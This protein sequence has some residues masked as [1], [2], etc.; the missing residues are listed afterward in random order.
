MGLLKKILELATPQ[1]TYQ[2]PT[3]DPYEERYFSAMPEIEAMWSVLYNLK[4]VTGEKADMFEQKCLQNISDFQHIPPANTQATREVP[5]YTR[6]AMLYEKQERYDE[7]IAVCAD[8][9]RR[10]IVYDGSKGQMY[11]RLTRLIRKSGKQVDSDILKL[12]GGTK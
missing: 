1:P 12:A 4:I 8:A 11:G 9:I 5:A 3:Q 6:L 2:A 10:G 7:A